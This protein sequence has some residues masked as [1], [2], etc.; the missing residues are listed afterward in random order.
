MLDHF[1]VSYPP[2]QDTIDRI[3]ASDKPTFRTMADILGVEQQQQVFGTREF[4]VTCC[5][6][7]ICCTSKKLIL[8]PDELVYTRVAGITQD[9]VKET[10]PYANI[11]SVEA[12]KSCGCCASLQ[13]PEEGSM[14]ESQH[15]LPG[16]GC[17]SAL[18]EE[19]RAELQAR[20]T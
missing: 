6:E 10:R 9:T 18:I 11:D 13:T 1:G 5:L 8:G 17:N 4:D 2:S 15:I 12:T 19:I 7:P 14:A 20:V 16:T 3:F